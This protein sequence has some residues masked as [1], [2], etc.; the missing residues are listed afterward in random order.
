MK[1]LK[2][3]PKKEFEVTV[4]KA[5]KL[6][7]LLQKLENS[8]KAD[9][10]IQKTIGYDDNKTINI[11]AINYATIITNTQEEIED[12]IQNEAENRI[13]KYMS[14]I[15]ILED[16]KDLKEKIFFF[17]ITSGVSQ[18]LSYIEKKKHMVKLYE[19][20]VKKVNP[21]DINKKSIA[22]K[23][24]KLRDSEFEKNEDF[25]FTYQ[26]WDNQSIKNELKNIKSTLLEYE[27]DI[28]SLNA[29]SKIKINLYENSVELAGL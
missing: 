7:F 19:E 21:Q 13:S 16:I 12:S 28:L 3:S 29:I 2:L 27:D 9:L 25:Q 18:K 1:E 20:L 5:H 15:E 4:N 17:N 6:L 14:A 26:Y 22:S 24:V 10:E 8:K 11:F 23:I